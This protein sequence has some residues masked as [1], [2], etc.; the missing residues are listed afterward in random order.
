MIRSPEES[1]AAPSRMFSTK[2]RYGRSAVESVNT[3]RPAAAV[4]D[5]EGVDL[6]CADRAQRVFGRHHP[7]H[8]VGARHRRRETSGVLGLRLR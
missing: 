4:G 8:G 1:V 2:I 7:S 6:A 3:R 5:D